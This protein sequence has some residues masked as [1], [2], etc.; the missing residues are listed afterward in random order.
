[1]SIIE[2]VGIVSGII[3]ILAF[4]FALWVWIRSEAKVRE[5]AKVIQAIHDIAG[6]AI[7]ESHTTLAED[8]E[9]KLRQAEKALGLV[10]SIRKLTGPYVH[11]SRVIE[12]T[13]FGMLIE[14]GIIWS[15]AMMWNIEASKQ[16]TE[17]WLVTPDLKPD[18]SD[19]IAG[20]IVHRNISNEKRYVYFYPDDLPHI[21]AE[22][23]KLLQ[24]LG[25][26]GIHSKKLMKRVKLVPLN[27]ARYGELFARANT[28]LYFRDEHRALSPRCFDEVILTKVSERGLFWQEHNTGKAEELCHLLEVELTNNVT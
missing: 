4:V 11:S 28:V 26:T 21:E 23:A 12:D 15:T 27:R 7:W 22:T 8:H 19:E 9:T 13:E 24:N 1:M 25:L 18:S 14:R 3:S 16:V 6:T 20:K 5:L 17:I 2:I 10:S